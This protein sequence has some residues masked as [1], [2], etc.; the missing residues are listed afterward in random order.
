MNDLTQI[1]QTL[2]EEKNRLLSE[3]SDLGGN[4]TQGE[5]SP[6]E[7]SEII[8]DDEIGDRMEELEENEANE[9]NIKTLINQIDSALAKIED[10]TYGQCDTCHQPIEAERLRANPAATTCITHR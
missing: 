10:G 6:N 9:E 4:M 3:L 1:K 7:T 8:S 2:T 5:V